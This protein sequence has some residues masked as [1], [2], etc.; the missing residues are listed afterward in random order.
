L[1]GFY[2]TGTFIREEY[3]TT[4]FTIYIYLAHPLDHPDE[5][6]GKAGCDKRHLS[7]KIRTLYNKDMS[8]K[9]NIFE[10]IVSVTEKLDPIEGSCF[11]SKYC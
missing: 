7:D 5:R 1:D 2:R 10:S 4:S 11:L 9:S 3:V 6:Q 8:A